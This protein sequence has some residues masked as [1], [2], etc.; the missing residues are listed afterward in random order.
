MS[1]LAILLPLADHGSL[2][3]SLVFLGPVAVMLVGLAIW[4]VFDRRRRNT[5]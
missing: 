2:Q 5:R 4:T 3:Q 1:A